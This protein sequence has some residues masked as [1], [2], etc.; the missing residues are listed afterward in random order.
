MG[1]G[2]KKEVHSRRSPRRDGDLASRKEESKRTGQSNVNT[3]SS[4][5]ALR[6]QARTQGYLAQTKGQTQRSSSMPLDLPYL[7]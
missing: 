2:K 1:E 4:S 3:D 6:V 7:P 5:V